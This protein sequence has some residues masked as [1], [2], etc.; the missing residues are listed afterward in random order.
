MGSLVGGI[1]RG[2]PIMIMGGDVIESG[3]QTPN[4]DAT[5]YKGTDYT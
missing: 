3:Y 5:I 2:T 1:M 4:P